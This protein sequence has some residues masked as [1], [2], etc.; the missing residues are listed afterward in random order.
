MGAAVSDH[1]QMA[2]LT[3]YL[4]EHKIPFSVAS[5]RADMLTEQIAHALAQ[6]GQRTMTVA[7]EAGSER[8]RAAINKGITEEH[9][10]NSIELAA[11][12]GMR[13][14]KLYY[15]IGLPGKRTRISL[16]RWR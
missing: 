7:P 12:A 8:M 5:M 4:V 2:E 16:K 10:Y 15:M 6:S 11:A 13:N 3:E 9:V 1:P 14:I